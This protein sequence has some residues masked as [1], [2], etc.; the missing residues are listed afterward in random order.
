QRQR[1]DLA[2]MFE[3]LPAAE[4]AD[5]FDG[6]AGGLYRLAK[7][8]TVPAL[9]HAGARRS[10]SQ[11]ESAV[12]QFLETQ[13]RAGEQRRAARTQLHHKRSE[14]DQRSLGGEVGQPG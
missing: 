6:L 12:R 2:S 9:H 7:T 1:I 5:D 8:D 10:D 11:Q 13:R 4:D 3:L 14:L